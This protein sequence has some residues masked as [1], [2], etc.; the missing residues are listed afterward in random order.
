MDIIF[1]QTYAGAA[2]AAAERGLMS[3]ESMT[4]VVLDVREEFIALSKSVDIGKGISPRGTNATGLMMVLDAS[5]YNSRAEEINQDI[6]RA[7]NFLRTQATRSPDVLP[8]ALE[9]SAEIIQEIAPR[10]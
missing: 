7:K 4:Q 10:N 8:Q 5:W 6:R 3:I 2:A 9:R 1:F